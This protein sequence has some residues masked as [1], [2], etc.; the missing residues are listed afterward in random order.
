MHQR[1]KETV[2]ALANATA[3]AT[4]IVHSLAGTD[5]SRT[6]NGNTATRKV[7]AAMVASRIH[8]RFAKHTSRS[9]QA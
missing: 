8:A 4:G 9:A 5:V 2:L 7:L 1:S 6:L 3:L